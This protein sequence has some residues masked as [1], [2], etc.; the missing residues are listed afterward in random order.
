MLVVAPSHL[1]IAIEMFTSILK[2]PEAEA[3][4][5]IWA[6]D[7]L[8]DYDRAIKSETIDGYNSV[9]RLLGFGR[10]DSEARFDGA[11]ADETVYICYSSGTTV[12]SSFIGIVC[13]FVSN[14]FSTQGTPKGV[15]VWISILNLWCPFH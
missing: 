14:A 7:R 9:G 12:S 11:E 15:E 6:M 3:R 4:S 5:R 13:T 1:S 10:L 2:V 8:W